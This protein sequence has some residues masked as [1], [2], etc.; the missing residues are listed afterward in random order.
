MY[1]RV[2]VCLFLFFWYFILTAYL[3]TLYLPGLVCSDFWGRVFAPF[4]HELGRAENRSWFLTES[5]PLPGGVFVANFRQWLTE[6]C[7]LLLFFFLHNLSENESK[8]TREAQ[9]GQHKRMCKLVG[10]AKSIV[11]HIAA[12]LSYAC[13]CS[14]LDAN[15]GM[16][17]ANQTIQPPAVLTLAGNV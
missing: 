13:W 7:L 11:W 4:D 10:C 9:K 12:T 2:C 8:K 1:A 14:N 16:K 5:R 17:I 6:F 3:F 15:C